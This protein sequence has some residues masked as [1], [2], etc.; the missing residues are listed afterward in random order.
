[1]NS[2]FTE[3]TV[4]EQMF[5]ENSESNMFTTVYVL[6]GKGHCLLVSEGPSWETQY[7]YDAAGILIREKSMIEATFVDKV[8]KHDQDGRII[9]EE[10]RENQY[11]CPLH[12]R[13]YRWSRDYRRVDM[14]G[15]Q[16][17]RLYHRPD[18]RLKHKIIGW[19]TLQSDE[20]FYK[21]DRDSVLKSTKRKMF[22]A[23]KRW[24]IIKEFSPSGRLLRE[25]HET[26]GKMIVYTYQDDDSG[27]WILREGRSGDGR[28]T[29]RISREI[30]Y[31]DIAFDRPIG[32]NGIV[33]ELLQ[34]NNWMR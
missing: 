8:Y 23:D 21:W 30:K 7:W 22:F 1:M 5:F 33:D 26:A 2:E 13:Q 14:W 29:S 31:G 17:C 27:N 4:R 15:E 3:I 12:Y 24:L 9:F 11:N 16:R 10:S 25:N 32:V 6:D 18:G 34:L 20:T 28:I 19:D